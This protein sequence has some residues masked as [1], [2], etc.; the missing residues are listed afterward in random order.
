MFDPQSNTR[1][2]ADKMKGPNH[3]GEDN[4]DHEGDLVGD[5]NVD[6]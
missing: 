4:E 1:R 5:Y 3:T 6:D 2:G